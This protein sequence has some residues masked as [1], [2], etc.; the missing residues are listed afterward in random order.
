LL[1]EIYNAEGAFARAERVTRV[2][3]TASGGGFSRA[4]LAAKIQHAHALAGLG[5]FEAARAELDSGVNEQAKLGDP[6]TVGLLHRA[7]A[8]LAL[9]EDDPASFEAHL[10]AMEGVFRPTE[11]PALISMCERLRHEQRRGKT[12]RSGEYAVRPEELPARRSSA[13]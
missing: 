7:C 5:A 1:A 3:A 8:Q 10:T 9:S 11:N 12:A 6:V 2:F 4:T 13:E